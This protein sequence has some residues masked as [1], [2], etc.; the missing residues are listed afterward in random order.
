MKASE[1]HKLKED[2]YVKAVASLAA[3]A[4]QH[5]NGI[6][7][8]V[9]V[10]VIA[11][12][13]VIWVAVSRSAAEEAAGALLAQAR[14]KARGV[15]WAKQ[16]EKEK[17]VKEVVAVCDQ[18]VADYPAADAAPLAL[19]YAGQL[20]SSQEK[21][22]EAAA[23]FRKALAMGKRFPALI[24]LARRGLA[25]ALEVSGDMEAAVAEYH[26]LNNGSVGI[27]SARAC[28]DIGRCCESLGKKDA[29]VQHYRKA[30][31]TGAGTMWQ[32]LADF[33]LT[34]LSRPSEDTS[35][36][37]ETPAS[38]PTHKKPSP[39]KPPRQG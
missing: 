34:A 35:R 28:W 13:A 31:E 4:R 12:A 2:K 21:P 22:K 15:Q 20:L 11:A 29:A 36:A 24:R 1:R 14:A 16:E 18:V 7:A 26:V 39:E 27:E 10:A 9:V 3:W 5:R 33:R 23:Y 30:V 25:E 17:T 37:D 38:P 19:V 6:T 8:A 32:I